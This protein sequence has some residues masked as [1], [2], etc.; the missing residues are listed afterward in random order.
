VRY[1][2]REDDTWDPPAAVITIRVSGP[3]DDR[4][5]LRACEALVDTGS[6]MSALPPDLII[7]LGLFPVDWQPVEVGIGPVEERLVFAAA[8]EMP[9]VGLRP[10]QVLEHTGSTFAL[11]GRDLLN[12]LVATFDGP[13]RELTLSDG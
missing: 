12:E 10:I 5:N 6:D 1:A 4:R 7:S 3:A 2:Y 11:V 13:Q 9:V 8:I